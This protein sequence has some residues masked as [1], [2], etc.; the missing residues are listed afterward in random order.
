[1]HRHMQIH[2]IHIQ[3]VYCCILDT[4]N[5]CSAQ[6]TCFGQLAAEARLLQQRQQLLRPASLTTAE[7]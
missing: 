3:S 2:I 5:V 6:I 7:I 1:M 4:H